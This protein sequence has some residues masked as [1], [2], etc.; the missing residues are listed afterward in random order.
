MPPRRAHMPVQTWTMQGVQGTRRA[1]RRGS[2]RDWRARRAVRVLLS[3]EG[4]HKTK[5]RPDGGAKY[6]GG[7]YGRLLRTKGAVILAKQQAGGQRV[8]GD[9][10]EALA[11]QR[12]EGTQNRCRYS[13][14]AGRRADR[15]TS[16]TSCKPDGRAVRGPR[17]P[18]QGGK[19]H[20]ALAVRGRMIALK[21]VADCVCQKEKR[22]RGPS[23]R[24]R[25][26]WNG[27]AA[28]VHGAGGGWVGASA[29]APA[30]LRAVSRSFRPGSTRLDTPG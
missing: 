23:G 28:T 19:Q 12:L 4:A 15:P 8:C 6:A 22:S 30:A 1:G 18:V 27:Q 10:D 16:P 26:F 7:I 29:P 14:L 24:S 25:G 21:T 9:S 5:S 3:S 2:R 13:I 17:L 11:R 20:G